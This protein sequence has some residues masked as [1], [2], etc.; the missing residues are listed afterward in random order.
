MLPKA[1]CGAL[2][3]ASVDE[4]TDQLPVSLLS[5]CAVYV[6]FITAKNYDFFTEVS[7]KYVCCES[8]KIEKPG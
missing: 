8:S 3:A 1:S 2:A 4:I 6:T 7:L 5:L